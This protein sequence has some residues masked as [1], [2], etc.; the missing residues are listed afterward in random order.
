[1]A[2]VA[3][4]SAFSTS[5]VQGF[6]PTSNATDG[7][8]T[9]RAAEEQTVVQL[10][11]EGATGGT[12]LATA[13]TQSGQ[14]SLNANDGGTGGGTSTTATTD[15]TTATAQT[16]DTVQLS[17]EGTVAAQAAASATTTSENGPSATAFEDTGNSEGDNQTEASQTLGQVVDVFA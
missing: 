1:M 15:T 6:T 10:E 8:E 11:T 9:D 12:D 2:D 13:V 4:V 16:Q 7:L 5:S 14:T 3:G 17:S